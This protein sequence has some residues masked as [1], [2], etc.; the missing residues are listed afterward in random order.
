MSAR[1]EARDPLVDGRRRVRH[2]AQD[3][4]PS[5]ASRRSIAAVGTAAAIERTTWSGESS[6]PISP[7]STSKSCGLTAIT[8][9]PAPVTASAFERV[10]VTPCR[11]PSSASRSSWRPVTTISSG[12]RQPV[13]SSPASSASPILPQPRMAIRRGS[14]V[15]C[16][17]YL[18]LSTSGFHDRPGI[19]RPYLSSVST[20]TLPSGFTT[21]RVL[22][23]SSAA[24]SP[25][26][27]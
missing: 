15:T 12:L 26:L 19:G 6:P 10:A 18:S 11:S 14:E 27:P 1:A 8:T 25:S 16:P 17:S 21:Q 7:S 9:T 4:A 5:S 22:V 20:V 13:L 24:R 3:R 2:R 23:F